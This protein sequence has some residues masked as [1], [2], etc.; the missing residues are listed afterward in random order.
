MFTLKSLHGDSTANQ[1]EGYILDN[2]ELIA[3]VNMSIW[4]QKPL[5]IT[6][7]PG[8]GKTELARKIAWEL[9]QK[10]GDAELNGYAPFSPTP[11]I[12]N[13]KTTS[14]ATDLF[15]YYDAIGHFQQRNIVPPLVVSNPDLATIHPDS[16]EHEQELESHPALSLTVP[17]I[18]L[19]QPDYS[20]HPFIEL[21]ALGLAILQ[22]F[23]AAKLNADPK[24]ATLSRLR[25]FAETVKEAPSSTV[26]LIDE[27][28]KAPRDFPNDLLNE[29]DRY[30]FTIK[31]LNKT[32]AANKKAKPFPAIVV[33]MTSNFEKNLPDAFLRRCLFYHVPMPHQQNLHDI[34]ASRMKPYLDEKYRNTEFDIKERMIS[35][36]RAV[37]KFL[38]LRGIT[39]DKKPATSELIEWIKALE[40]HDFFEQGVDFSNLTEGQKLI[41]RYTLPLLA[42]TRSDLVLLKGK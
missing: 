14:A 11:L 31:E 1:P 30:E 41:L 24:L 27:I 10:E 8:T 40:L 32:I 15:Y 3:A 42:K 21:N 36:D 22:T 28:D 12:F 2:E 4:L 37:Q 18:D 34:V 35:Y 5:L 13:T 6:G 33:L 25:G 23:G 29:I 16:Q 20:A 38:A 19:P 9:S 26:V 39:A 17:A 7:E